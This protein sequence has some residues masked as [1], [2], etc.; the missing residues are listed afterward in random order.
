MF[1]NLTWEKC[2]YWRCEARLEKVKF[3]QSSL[4]HNMLKLKLVSM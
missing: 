4:L 3:E 1:L 2:I